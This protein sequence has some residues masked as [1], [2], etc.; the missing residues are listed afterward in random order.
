MPNIIGITGGIG[1]GKTAVTDHLQGKGI[2]IVDADICAREVVEPGSKA[3]IKIAQ[4]F[5][6]ILVSDGSLNRAKLRSIIFNDLEQKQWLESLLHPLIGEQILTHIKNSNSS[7]T[8][9]AS[10]LLLETVQRDL[11]D[12]IVVVDAT[13]AVQIERTCKRDSNDVEQV[14]RIISSQMPRQE[15]IA[16]ADFVIDN[17]TCSLAELQQSV[18]KLHQQLL[19]L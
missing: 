2:T 18:D 6:D 7:Y 12:Y 16:K 9:L 5:D 8:V 1:S 17:S 4:R 15:R 19:S 11:C 14:K 13:E 3:L 10:P